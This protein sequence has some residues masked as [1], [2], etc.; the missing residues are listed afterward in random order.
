[1]AKPLKNLIIISIV[2]FS[3]GIVS[4]YFFYNPLD[5]D[6]FPKCFFYQ[7]TNLHCPGCGTQRAI[8]Q[9]LQ[10]NIASGLSHNL[11]LILVV[12]VVGYQGIF[13]VLTH[14][15]KKEFNNIFH[16][17]IVTKSILAIVLLFWFLRNIDSYPFT[18]LAP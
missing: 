5:S 3:L 6:L 12:F 16:N 9:L 2:V 18:I 13:Y 8:H 15:L 11:L 4:L 7:I 17:S 1:M 10:G 14:F